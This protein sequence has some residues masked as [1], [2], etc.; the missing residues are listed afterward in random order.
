MKKNYDWVLVILF[1][2]NVLTNMYNQNIDATLGWICALM[3]TIRL[4]LNKKENDKE[5]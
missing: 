2:L 5:I 1:S 4:I 3:M